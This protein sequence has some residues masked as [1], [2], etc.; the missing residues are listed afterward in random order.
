[1]MINNDYYD[2]YDY[3]DY[4]D[5]YDSYDLYLLLNNNLNLKSLSLNHH[6]LIKTCLYSI[7]SLNRNTPIIKIILIIKIP[8]KKSEPFGSL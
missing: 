7:S 2:R 6:L 5:Y 3:Y 8:I 1:M 4:Y